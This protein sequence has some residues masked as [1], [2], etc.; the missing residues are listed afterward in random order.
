MRHKPCWSDNFPLD[1]WYGWIAAMCI[2]AGILFVTECSPTPVHAEAYL[3]LAGGVSI[4]QH[5]APDG[6]WYQKGLNYS[7]DL[8]AFSW[9][10]GAGWQFTKFGL[11]A[12]YVNLGTRRVAST[13][14]DDADYDIKAHKCLRNCS[15]TGNLTASDALHGGEVLASYRWGAGDWHPYI[16]LG[17]AWML[18]RFT[19]ENY[20]LSF[21]QKL[22]SGMPMAVGGMGL[23]YK[24][25]Y[26]E[27]DFYSLVGKQPDSTPISTQVVLTTFGLHIPLGS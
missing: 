16:K 9:K 19:V 11:E 17:G 15:A 26:A 7:T 24:W 20:N 23:A 2:L 14:V 3:N 22:Y 27:T 10:A 18:N 25:V 8:H 5:T 12:N 6:I 1:L 13:F 21:T 4:G